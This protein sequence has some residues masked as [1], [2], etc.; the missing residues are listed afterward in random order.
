MFAKI[1]Y[2]KVFTRSI[3]EKPYRKKDLMPVKKSAR[4]F[5]YQSNVGSMKKFV[6]DN[7]N[8][9]KTKLIQLII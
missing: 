3:Y 5:R 6:M 7:Q 1:F 9:S 2:S 4:S 8:F